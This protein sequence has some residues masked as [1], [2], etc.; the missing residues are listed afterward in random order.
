[1][2]ARNRYR[3]RRRGSF[4]RRNRVGQYRNMPSFRGKRRRS[5]GYTL[6]RNG[7]ML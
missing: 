6:G 5:R 3:S 7:F 2:A 4:L 1:M